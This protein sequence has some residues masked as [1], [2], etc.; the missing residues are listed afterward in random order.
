MSEPPR[1]EIKTVS[2]FL[3]VPEDRIEFCLA[4]FLECIRTFW[5]FYRIIEAITEQDGVAMQPDF[6][7]FPSFTWIDDGAKN[8]Y[9]DITERESHERGT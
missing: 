6:A 2:D 8:Q 5:G 3:Q 7:D 4:E 9:L 1:Y